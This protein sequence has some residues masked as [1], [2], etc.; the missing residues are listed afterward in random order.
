MTESELR[1]LSRSDLLQL[2]VEQGKELR[3]LKEKYEAAKA[4]LADRRIALDNA[5]SIAEA[6]LK[7]NGVFE[8]AQAACSQYTENIASLS[9]RQEA[10]C[11]E[12]EAESRRQANAMLEEARKKS[13][14]MINDAKAQTQTYWNSFYEMVE[15]NK[16][17][18]E[19]D[20]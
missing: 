1:K 5:G 14:E 19:E 8:A 6:A 15:Q 7:L 18:R 16:Q 4:E 9:R 2:L 11:A 3:D 20:K 13:V 12:M 10:V 17:S